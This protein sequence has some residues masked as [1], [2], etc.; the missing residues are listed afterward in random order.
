MNRLLIEAVLVIA[1]IASGYLYFTKTVPAAKPTEFSAP[2]NVAPEVRRAE[3]VLVTP[4]KPIKVYAAG[5]KAKLKLPPEVEADKNKSVIAAS[6]VSSSDNPQTVTTVLDTETGESKTYVKE[7][8]L[9][10]L[11]VDTHGEAGI[12]YGLKNGKQAV[13]LE[14]RQNL[15]Q[16]K[17]VRLQAVG[18]LDQYTTGTISPDNFVGLGLAY[19]W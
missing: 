11:A 16:V 2:A 13:R 14:L 5:V 6:R 7:E 8:P 10:W 12:Y 15:L 4:T 19:R 1:L 3:T 9:P 18:S 17:A